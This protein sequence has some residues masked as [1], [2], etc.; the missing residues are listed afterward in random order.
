[1][2]IAGEIDAL[3]LELTRKGLRPRYIVIGK[4]QYIQWTRE[5]E[6]SN[7]DVDNIYQDCDIVI[8]ETSI[9]EVVPTPKDMYDYYKRNR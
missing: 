5:S 7:R 1:M 3:I 6:N 9:L 4:D 2:K 8:C